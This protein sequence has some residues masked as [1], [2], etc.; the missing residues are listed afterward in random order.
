[1]KV[2][3][4]NFANEKYAET[5]K[6]NTL[7]AKI[8][9]GVDEVIECTPKMIDEEFR[10]NNNSILS[11]KRGYGLWL[12]KP[13]FIKKYLLEINDNDYLFYSDSGAL[14]CRSIKP[15]I[16]SMGDEEI[17]ISDVPLIE[18]EWT[19]P[20][21]F[22]YY[23]CNEDYVCKTP[24]IQAAFIIFKKTANTIAFVDEWLKGCMNSELIFPLDDRAEKGKCI[25]HREDQS[26]LSVMCKLNGIRP[27]K[28]ATQFGQYPELYKDL[29]RT[30]IPL[31]HDEKYKIIIIHHRM[32]KMDRVTAIKLFIKTMLPNG[33]KK[34]I[35]T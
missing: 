33:W 30:Y 10:L 27:H 3:L 14:F 21:V 11:C 29:G 8:F 26:I 15:L 4:I 20:S 31:K 17:W 7:T 2:T 16:K 35:K 5:Q 13:Y 9:A 34:E 22:S 28:D 24:Q 32:S 12:W 19:K 23:N 18:E 25:S 1:M 6:F